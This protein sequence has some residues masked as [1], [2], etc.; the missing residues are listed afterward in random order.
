MYFNHE[1][2]CFII[3]NSWRLNRLELYYLADDKTWRNGTV[4]VPVVFLINLL[5]PTSML[6]RIVGQER[7]RFTGLCFSFSV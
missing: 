7:N 1:A 2:I 3:K 4:I 6:F 5:Y